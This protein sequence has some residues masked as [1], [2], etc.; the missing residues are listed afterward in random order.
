MTTILVG[1]DGT[2][3]SA[4]AIAPALDSAEVGRAEILMA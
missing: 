3:R 2:E 4:D 1:V